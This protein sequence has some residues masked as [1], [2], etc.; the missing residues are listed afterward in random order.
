MKIS[1][2]F[3]A[4]LSLG[5]GSSYHHRGGIVVVNGLS[6]QSAPQRVSTTTEEIANKMKQQQQ[7]QKWFP[8]RIQEDV[9]YTKLVSSLYL[10]H[11]VVETKDIA[12]LALEEYLKTT[13]SEDPFGD[14]AKKV[15]ACAASREE[16]GKIGWVDMG[17]G[18]DNTHDDL[19]SSISIIPTDVLDELC[20]YAPKAGDV[21]IIHSVATQQ[22][23]IVR[24]EEL[25]IR[26][27]SNIAINDDKDVRVGAHA[28]YNAV[29]PRRKLKG[30][31]VMPKFPNLEKENQDDATKSYFIQ[32]NGC[33]MNVADS[34]RLAG[35]LQ[36][37]LGLEPASKGDQADVVLFNTCSIRDHAEQK[38][39][40]ILG[41]Y[42][43]R[44]RK[45]EELALIV[46]GCVAQQEGED[47]LRRV[48]E[49]DV[50]LGPQ[51]VPH[52][53]NVLE[54]VQW[55]HQIVVTAPMLHQED[56]AF[57]KPVRGHTV[58]AWVNI[59]NG[60]NEHCTYCVVPATRGMEQ[61]RSMENILQEC[62]NLLEDGYK[63]MLMKR[64]MPNN[65]FIDSI[66]VSK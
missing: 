49:V 2:N 26:H 10:R 48:P 54:S 55:G 34:E 22:F 52:L 31:G 29:L 23:H 9:D 20:T 30:A 58:R 46:T 25:L 51:Y 41:P 18:D 45:G 53:K 40:D 21:H 12:Q 6:T 39:Y 42:C 57:S 11:I 63:G 43:A 38:L 24:V 65:S 60:C 33:Q 66:R 3:L 27:N 64:A 47:L 4:L 28:G 61:S 5:G 7:Q 16:G 56:D 8:R 59:I 15:S 62:Q 35:I 13:S 36:N 44:K 17:V 50:V 1:L 14:I 32:T 19:S 37:D